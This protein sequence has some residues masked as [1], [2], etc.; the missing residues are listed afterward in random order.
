MLRRLVYFRITA[1]GRQF[2]FLSSEITG[3]W[4]SKTQELD[5]GVVSSV[6]LVILLI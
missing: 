5:G 3:R 4:G 2:R 1:V 6:V